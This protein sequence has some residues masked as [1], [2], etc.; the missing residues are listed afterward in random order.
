L[1]QLTALDDFGAE[2][3]AP[4]IEDPKKNQAQTKKLG[5]TTDPKNSDVDNQRLTKEKRR[6]W[7]KKGLKRRFHKKLGLVLEIGR[8]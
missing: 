6:I 4:K 5:T 3:H 2:K 8:G 7:A 1:D